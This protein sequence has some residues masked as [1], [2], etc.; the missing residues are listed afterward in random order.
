MHKLGVYGWWLIIGKWD[1][2]DV[3]HIGCQLCLLLKTGLKGM[4]II[5]LEWYWVVRG[6]LDWMEG[7]VS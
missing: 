7:L 6:G 5:E 3:D 2:Q 1:V 4:L